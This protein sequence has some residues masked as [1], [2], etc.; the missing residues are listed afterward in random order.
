MIAGG[1]EQ[2]RKEVLAM[3]FYSSPLADLLLCPDGTIV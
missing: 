3:T 1:K 2:K